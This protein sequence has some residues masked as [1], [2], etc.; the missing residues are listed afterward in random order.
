MFESN[1]TW[2]PMPVV[3]VVMA[4]SGLV[5]MALVMA[6]MVRSRGPVSDPFCS[7]PAAQAN[8]P[9]AI[10]RERYARGGMDHDEFELVLDRL[11]R[12]SEIRPEGTIS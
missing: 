1:L 5:V 2:L 11:Q 9:L 7:H 4:I 10:L 3:P 6:V 12:T 8:D